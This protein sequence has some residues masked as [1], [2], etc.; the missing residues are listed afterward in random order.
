VLC[1]ET[2]KGRVERNA[3]VTRVQ[4]IDALFDRTD[5]FVLSSEL[6]ERDAKQLLQRME[7]ARRHLGLDQCF[8]VWWK[9]DA[10]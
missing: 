10:T 6:L 7:V 8:D 4:Q 1:A 3:S 9:I 2:I 5:I